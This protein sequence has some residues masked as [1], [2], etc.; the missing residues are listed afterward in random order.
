M[1]DEINYKV[2]SPLKFYT[3]HILPLVYDDSLSYLEM[4]GKVRNK[5]NELI[6]YYNSS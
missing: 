2:I 5:L 4:L 6:D 1:A 3:Q